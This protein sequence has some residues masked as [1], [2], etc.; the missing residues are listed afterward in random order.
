[1]RKCG[2]YLVFLLV[3]KT[4]TQNKQVD[5]VCKSY[6]YPPNG[7]FV[8]KYQSQYLIDLGKGKVSN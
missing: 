6:A 2:E 1:M 8:T 7:F 3:V 5:T 4:L